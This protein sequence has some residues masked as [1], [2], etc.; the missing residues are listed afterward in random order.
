M[1]RDTARESAP[2]TVGTSA[3][4]EA[5]QVV[6]VLVEAE[7]TATAADDLGDLTEDPLSFVGGRL[8]TAAAESPTDGRL[9]RSQRTKRAIVDAL[10]D[11]IREGHMKPSSAE[12]ADRAGVTQ[13]TLFNQF[14]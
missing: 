8:A 6:E 14:G 1:T 4:P 9:L 12:I 7:D 3:E 2:S 13:R 11:L 10:L 5:E